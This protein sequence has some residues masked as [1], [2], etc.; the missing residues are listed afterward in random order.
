MRTARTIGTAC[1]TAVTLLAAGA[2][3]AQPEAAGWG[4]HFVRIHDTDGNGTVSMDEV[5]AEQRRILG[6]ADVDGNGVLSVA[7]FRRRGRLIHRLGTATLFD[8]LDT[9]GDRNIT[10]EELAA[11]AARWFARYDANG[12][13]A[14][15]AEE[16]PRHR[17]HRRSGK[18]GP[19]R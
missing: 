7:E 2:A 19:R 5:K 3:F 17:W 8:M 15:A 9:D 13:G 12:D 11:P 18:H 1:L 10:A 6:A 4:G 14:M 16:L